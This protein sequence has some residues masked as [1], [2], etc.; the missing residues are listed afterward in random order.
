MECG[1]SVGVAIRFPPSLKDAY[2]RMLP[3]S[4]GVKSLFFLF[5][6]ALQARVTGTAELQPFEVLILMV[7]SCVSATADTKHPAAW[8]LR[9]KAGEVLSNALD[10]KR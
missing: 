6:T 1:K 7:C 9:G 4:V 5:M 2:N 3:S 10:L 8:V